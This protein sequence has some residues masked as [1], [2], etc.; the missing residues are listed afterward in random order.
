MGRL[1]DADER[2]R[3]KRSGRHEAVKRERRDT[4]I[5][6]GAKMLTRGRK[7]VHFVGPRRLA[8]A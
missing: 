4:S 8:G 2:S 7:V 1:R 5:G 3:E 6:G